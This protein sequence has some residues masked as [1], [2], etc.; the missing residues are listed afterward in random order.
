VLY[1][2]AAIA[3]ELD[4]YEALKISATGAL[5]LCED[6]GDSWGRAYAR[7]TVGKYLIRTGNARDAVAFMEQGLD[8]FRKQS[9]P[10]GQAFAMY[11]LVRALRIG[12]VDVEYVRNRKPL[13]EA[14]R[15]AGDR[16][17]LA[18]VLVIE[19]GLGF[20]KRGE[21]EQA[22]LALLESDALLAE[23]GSSRRSLNRYYLAQLYYLRG[24]PEKAKLEART[25]LEYCQRVGEK[26]THAFICMF[27]GM[28]SEMQ[29]ALSDALHH[30]H[31]YLDLMKEI[32]T[33]RHLAWGY[34]LAGRL[35][36]LIDHGEAALVDLRNGIEIIKEC[37]EEPGDLS[38]FF[39]Q[40]SGVLTL[41]DPGTAVRLLSF[42]ECLGTNQKDP[43][44]Y[45]PYLDRFLGEAHQKVSEEEFNSAWIAGSRMTTEQAIDMVERMLKEI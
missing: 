40:M 23:T 16:Y 31:E 14:V 29:G 33:P 32:G 38:Y 37:C 26:N 13:L 30:Q 11:H 9:D 7:I 24:D 45:Q 18:D 35:H 36:Y 21:W 8:E 43:I 12:R 3:H 20:M 28:I 34:A 15:A 2:K 25:A 1:C 17:L 6:V 22:E 42:T 39:V 4:D 5:A 19:Y 27:L 10:W 44:F 41:R